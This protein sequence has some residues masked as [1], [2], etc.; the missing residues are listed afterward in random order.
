MSQ[1]R[2]NWNKE[3]AEK[4]S[5]RVLLLFSSTDT[6]NCIGVNR[7]DS[8]HFFEYRTIFDKGSICSDIIS[9]NKGI[10]TVEI[11]E[12]G[13]KLRTTCD[14]D[15]QTYRQIHHFNSFQIP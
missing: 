5:E 15:S 1:R 3:L 2:S 4:C 11:E 12:K 6:P 8:F 10:T 9:K 7:R 14:F 13:K